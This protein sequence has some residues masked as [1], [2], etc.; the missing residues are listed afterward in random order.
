[1]SD[2]I[3]YREVESSRIVK[4]GYDYKKNRLE[5]HFTN[6]H[7]YQYEQVPENY[8]M[9]CLLSDSIGRYFFENIAET[10]PYEILR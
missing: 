6:G 8:Y 3:E 2:H 10:F 9:E 4:M 7:I 1:M 5:V